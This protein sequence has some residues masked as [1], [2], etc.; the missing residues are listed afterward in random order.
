MRA[1]TLR[2]SCG[3]DTADLE[4]RHRG[5]RKWAHCGCGCGDQ[6]ISWRR[7]GCHH[8]GRCSRR[9]CCTA[10]A[11][12]AAFCCHFDDLGRRLTMKPTVVFVA[13]RVLFVLV[14]VI[15]VCVVSLCARPVMASTE[16]GV[17][18]RAERSLT[19]GSTV[20]VSSPAPRHADEFHVAP[21]AA[22]PLSAKCSLTLRGQVGACILRPANTNSMVACISF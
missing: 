5:S 22:T 9:S 15:L 6:V 17:C 21:R 16:N 18:W 3:R 7:A 20:N 11:S 19:F 10:S 14:C 2:R 4:T 13:F 12:A 8:I 1:A